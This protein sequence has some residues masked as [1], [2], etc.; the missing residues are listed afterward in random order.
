MKDYYKHM[1]DYRNEVLSVI[2]SIMPRA[3]AGQ[4]PD[5]M[6]WLYLENG[7]RSRSGGD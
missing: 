1:N 3:V 7:E 4:E 5:L 2:L 6:T